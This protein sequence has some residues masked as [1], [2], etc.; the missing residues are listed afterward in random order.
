MSQSV[1]RAIVNKRNISSTITE[2]IINGFGANITRAY[3][4]GQTD[5]HY[6]LPQGT[7]ESNGYSIADIINAIHTDTGTLPDTILYHDRDAGDPAM[8]AQWYADTVLGR[9]PISGEISGVLPATHLTAVNTAHNDFVAAK[10]TELQGYCTVHEATYPR[11]VETSEAGVDQDGNACTLVTTDVQTVT[12]SHTISDTLSYKTYLTDTDFT[13]D[14]DGLPTGFSIDLETYFTS[15]V[16]G[17]TYATVSTVR[18]ITPT[19]VD[20]STGTSTNETVLDTLSWNTYTFAN[21]SELVLTVNE[22][23]PNYDMRSQKYYVGYK[24]GNVVGTW[25]YDTSTEEHPLLGGMLGESTSPFYPVVPLRLHNEDLCA[26][27]ERETERFTTSKRLLDILNMDILTLVDGVNENPDVDDI[28]H[29]FVMMGVQL[30]ADSEA[31]C[32][33]LAG[34]FKHM[35]DSTPGNG[36]IPSGINISEGGLDMRISWEKIESEYVTGRIGKKGFAKSSTNIS[37]DIDVGILDL[38]WGVITFSVQVDD[39]IYQTVTVYN[40]T[41]TN[42]I[43]GGKS[44]E[45]T[46][47]D[48]VDEENMNFVIPLHHAVVQ[49]LPVTVRN[50]LYFDALQ[51]VFYSYELTKVKWYQQEWFLGLVEIVGFVLTAMGFKGADTIAKFLIALLKVAVTTFAFKLAVEVLS[52]ELALIIAVAFAAYGISEGFK[53]GFGV[54]G[55][56]STKLLEMVSGIT[57]GIQSNIGDAF[58]DLQNEVDTFSKN[59]KEKMDALEEINKEF[60]LTGILDPMEFLNSQPFI[61]LNESVSNY[62][63]RTIHTGNVGTLAFDLIENYHSI[64]LELP[65]PEHNF[66]Y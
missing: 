65:K 31:A 30:Q 33:Y 5:Y 20:G 44:V 2:D 58:K 24:V 45:T 53:N 56:L 37:V 48:T 34:F 4:Y 51:L 10:N 9:D 35:L 8:E 38:Q 12:T 22:A 57:S 1:I 63:D 14:T 42:M 46:L 55:S 61:N 18:T 64:Q 39:D 27:S 50:D 16:N 60:G 62:Y 3:S 17:V 41:H 29:A 26:E 66:S 49:A 13:V 32:R 19:Y 23:L 11:T 28:D 47:A 52:P 40:P 6:G 21:R 7:L 25:F 43:Y 36:L 15:I 54:E 59:A